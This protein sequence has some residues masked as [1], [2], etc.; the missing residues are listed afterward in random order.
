MKVETPRRGVCTV[1]T[2][3]R[4]VC[5]GDRRPGGASL[6]IACY[7]LPL[8]LWIIAYQVPTR[9][10]LLV[11]GDVAH[12]RRLDE[13]PFLHHINGSEPPD[14]SNCPGT[15]TRQ[16]WWWQILAP[17]ERPYRWTSADTT[18]AIPG[19]GGGLYAVEIVARGQPGPVPTPSTWHVGAGPALIVDLP[20]H[21]IRRYHILAPADSSGDLRVTMHTQPFI[22]Q[23]DPRELG[24]VLYELRV[25]QTG[26]GPRVPAWPQLGWL[27]ITVAVTYGIARILSVGPRLSYALA[28]ILTLSATLALALARPEIAIVTPILAGTSLASALIA[29]VGWAATRKQ[30]TAA[31]FTRQV[32]ALTLLALA[33]R[34]GG[35]F[36]PHALYSDSA[37]HANKLISLILGHVFQTAGLPSEAGGGQAPYPTGFYILLLPGQLLLPNSARVALMQVGTAILDSLMLPLIALLIIRAGLGR[38]AALIGAACYLLPITT[39]ESFSIGELANIGGQ[40]IAM[41]FIAL[42][43]L[44]TQAPSGKTAMTT[45]VAALAAGLLAHSGVTLSLGAF[46]A[47]AWLIALVQNTPSLAPRRLTLIAALALGVALLTYYSAPIYLSSILDRVGGAGSGT[48]SGLA[49]LTIL[50]ETASSIFGLTPPRSRGRALPPLLGGLVLGGLGILWAQRGGQPKASGLRFS[51]SALWL[52]ALITQALLLVADQGVRWLLFL[53]PALCL[54]AGPFLSAVYRRGRIGRTV[55]ILAIG[56]TLAHGLLIWVVQIRDYYH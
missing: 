41:S 32:L 39:L 54:S 10:T 13:D 8:I 18:A 46:T 30:G 42:L 9:Q 24:F 44:S 15:T 6:Q 34:V 45:A 25:A 19:L 55:A 48:K 14:S 7:L 5:T 11:G 28:A 47:A 3:R 33:L 16:C 22:A 29:A 20:P 23:G 40:S 38:R 12:Q 35:M 4:G 26:G 27:T 1:E 37:F 31:P 2:P 17:G 52:G 53:Y 43:T 50:S 36:H 49:P 21:T 56:S 51:L